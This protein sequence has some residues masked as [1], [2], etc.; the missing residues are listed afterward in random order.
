MSTGFNIRPA[1]APV[2]TSAVSSASETADNAVAAAS[3]RLAYFHTL[4]L[5]KDAPTRRLATDRKA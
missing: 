2:V 5:T 3:Y 4:G 1:G